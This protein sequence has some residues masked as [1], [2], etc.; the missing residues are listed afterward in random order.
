[1]GEARIIKQPPWVSALVDQRMAA[2]KSG[3]VTSS[4]LFNEKT[5]VIVVPLRDMPDGADPEYWER[6]CDKCDKYCPPVRD[7]DDWVEDAFFSGMVE[8]RANGLRIILFYGSC[9]DCLEAT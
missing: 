1:M 2:L 3:D 4:G 7:G 8:E 6:V 5:K 9:P